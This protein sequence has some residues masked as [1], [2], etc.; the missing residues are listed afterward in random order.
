MPRRHIEHEHR[1]AAS[2]CSPIE[3]ARDLPFT[4]VAGEE[5][6]RRVGVAM[7]DRDAGIGEPANARRDPRHDAERD[8]GSGEGESFLSA[9]SENAWIAALEAQHPVAIPC[10]LDE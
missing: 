1:R 4:I 5:G 3:P 9:P 6:N 8:A 10:C 7:S 2:N